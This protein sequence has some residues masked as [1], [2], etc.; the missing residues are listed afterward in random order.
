[1]YR[2]NIDVN[3]KIIYIEVSGSMSLQEII[4]FIDDICDLVNK[5]GQRQYSMLIAAQRLDP[6]SQDKLPVVQQVA[7]LALQWADKIALVYGN[8]TIT[9]MQLSKIVTGA[10]RNTHSNTPIASFQVINKAVDFLK[11]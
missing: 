6:L 7:E 8:R 1:M 2:I 11:Q 3:N 9:R 5:F 4:S 10:R